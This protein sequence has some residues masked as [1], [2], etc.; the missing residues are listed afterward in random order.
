MARG[1]SES[2]TTREAQIMDVIW[3]L[4]EATADQIREAMDDAPH[5]STIRTLLR[6]LE[7]KGYATHE[8]IGKAYVYRAAVARK[9]AQKSAIA[10][11]LEQFF[12]GSAEDLVVR[13][14]EDEAITA[15]QLD[16]LRRPAPGAAEA[17]SS[18]WVSKEKGKDQTKGKTRK[19]RT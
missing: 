17:K 11:L 18:R 4:G 2:L 16:E 5:D 9:K 8:A 13:L 7:S 14:I 12:G 3:R 6:V 1:R 15:E 19:G 10:S